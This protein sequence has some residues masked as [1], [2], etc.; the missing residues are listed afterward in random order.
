MNTLPPKALNPFI[1][2]LKLKRVPQ[3]IRPLEGNLNVMD[4]E[5]EG[6]LILVLRDYPKG[7]STQ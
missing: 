3:S 7:P 2:R 1:R 4:V 5:G 6:C